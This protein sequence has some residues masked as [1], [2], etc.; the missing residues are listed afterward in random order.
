[1]NEWTRGWR[2]VT[3]CSLYE[4]GLWPLGLSL[5]GGGGG[6]MALSGRAS[7][8]SC[9]WNWFSRWTSCCFLWPT[10]NRWLSRKHNYYLSCTSWPNGRLP[11]SQRTT[12]PPTNHLFVI[13]TQHLFIST[14]IWP[15]N[16][17]K[18]AP[19]GRHCC[20]QNCRRHML[21]DIIRYSKWP[22]SRTFGQ[23]TIGRWTIDHKRMVRQQ[24]IGQTPLQQRNKRETLWNILNCSLARYL[25]SSFRLLKY[26]NHHHFVY[27]NTQK[28]RTP[29]VT[30][31]TR[32]LVTNKYI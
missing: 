20:G 26:T 18:I 13:S 22:D 9:R 16:M 31:A 7:W 29:A 2:R 25:S 14:A 19:S 11:L 17:C 24:T 23:K 6:V 30:A 5:A 4:F 27:W 12:H 28:D 32:V 3:L 1:M 21:S 10:E 8:R 15:I